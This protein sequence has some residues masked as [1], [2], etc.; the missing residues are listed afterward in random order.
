MKTKQQEMCNSGCTCSEKAKETVGENAAN[1]TEESTPSY[2]YYSKVLQKPF[3][4]LHELQEAEAEFNRVHALEL[5]KKEEKA[6]DAKEVQDA[7]KAYLAT[8][9]ETNKKVFEAKRKYLELRNAFIEK[10]GS[11]HQSYYKD[12]KHE[13]VTVSDLIDEA[14]K[15]FPFI[16]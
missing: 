13:I 3:D 11:Y 2:G 7:Y 6:A 16:W 1:A 4:S 5:K 15:S 12:N 14:L 10:H 9:E 8:I